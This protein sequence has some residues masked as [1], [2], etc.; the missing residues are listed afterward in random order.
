MRTIIFA[1]LAG[2]QSPELARQGLACVELPANCAIWTAD[3][4]AAHRE[5]DE[6]RELLRRAASCTPPELAAEIQRA[7]DESLSLEVP[8]GKGC[9]LFVH[10]D[11]VEYAEGI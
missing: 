10:P 8:R 3:A 2:E 6:M 4:G 9:T 7:L 5:V 11:A 1:R